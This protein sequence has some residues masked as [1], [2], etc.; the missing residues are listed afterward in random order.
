MIILFSNLTSLDETESDNI[1]STFSGLFPTIFFLPDLFSK[2]PVTKP[3]ILRRDWEKFESSKFIFD[4][5][6]NWEQILYNENNDVNFSLNEYLSKVDSLLDAHAP[7]KSFNKKELKFFT[8][9]WIALSLQ[10][11]I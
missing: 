7:I 10:N 9:P 1:T 5:N 2:V 3:N 6:Q 4:F 8:K 11:S